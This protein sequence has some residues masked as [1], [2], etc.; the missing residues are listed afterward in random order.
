MS[1]GSCS[2]ITS[3]VA[4]SIGGF[5]SSL[6]KASHVYDQPFLYFSA[7]AVESVIVLVSDMTAVFRSGGRRSF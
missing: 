2:V 3:S 6:S 7:K 5:S 4:D 1:S